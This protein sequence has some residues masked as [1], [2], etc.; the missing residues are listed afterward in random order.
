MGRLV[1]KWQVK[2]QDL[3][4]GVLHFK[5]NEPLIIHLMWG[6]TFRFSTSLVLLAHWCGARLR[7][8]KTLKK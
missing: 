3:I 4:E 2:M 1:K 7:G 6:L 5:L 8:S